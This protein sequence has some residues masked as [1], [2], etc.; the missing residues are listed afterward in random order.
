MSD[1]LAELSKES[2][3]PLSA[4][5][6]PVLYLFLT[7]KLDIIYQIAVWN[8]L[9]VWPDDGHLLLCVGLFFFFV[10]YLVVMSNAFPE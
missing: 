8:I 4:Q 9:C 5:L 6:A 7:I 3:S 2:D 10:L 1:I